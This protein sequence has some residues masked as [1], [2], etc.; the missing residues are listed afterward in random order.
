MNG[1]KVGE[2]AVLRGGGSIF[3]YEPAWQAS[4]RGRALSL[5]LPLTAD[6]EVRGPQ[7]EH[8]FDNLLPENPQVRRR[9]RT[10]FQ[11]DST[12]PFDLLSAVGRDCAGAVQLLPPDREPEGW[13]RVEAKALS[14]ADVERLLREVVNPKAPGSDDSDDFRISIAGA[15]EKTALLA[16][17]GKWF[18]PQGATPT[19]SILKLPLGIVGN[20][21]G[22]LR[23]SVENEWLCGQLLRELGFP[24]AESSIHSFGEQKVLAV[25]RFDRRWQ[26]TDAD[27]VR[28]KSFKPGRGVWIARIPQEDFCQAMGLPPTR[29]YQADGGPSIANGLEL[30]AGSETADVDRSIF[31]RV[32]FVFWLLAATDGHGKNFSLYHRAG[33]SFGMTPLYD[34]LSAWPIIG[35][36]RNQLAI[37]KAKLA[38]AIPG[39]RQHYRLTEIHP[40]HWKGLVTEA[41]VPQMWEDLRGLAE[42]VP[43]VF[44]KVERR[45]PKS[46]PSKVFESIH[47]GTLAH[48][49][50]FLKASVR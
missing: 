29:K 31:L 36:G 6:L 43:A 4:K 14:V 25:E 28:K 48:A 27:E 34:V 40:R 46:F 26:G 11:T 45:L 23:D 13:D 37:Q 5:S 17:A 15:Q 12:D 1:E 7:V 2:W 18:R 49:T 16:M 41:G 38:M 20:F 10:R 44:N 42:Q 33:G 50:R 35:R 47:K 39:T 21:Q 3:R 22:D 8:F 32:Q 9:M 24:V 19:T 30:L